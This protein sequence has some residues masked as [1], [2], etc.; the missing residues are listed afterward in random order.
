MYK[1]YQKPGIIGYLIEKFV[2]EDQALDKPRKYSFISRFMDKLHISRKNNAD[3]MTDEMVRY[4]KK[5]HDTFFVASLKK[6]VFNKENKQK[7]FKTYVKE[8][9][10]SKSELHNISRKLEA[11]DDILLDVNNLKL[12]YPYISQ[13]LDKEIKKFEEEKKSI[14]VGDIDKQIFQQH[15]ILSYVNCIIP[16]LREHKQEGNLDTLKE[17]FYVVNEDLNKVNKYIVTANGISEIVEL[18]ANNPTIDKTP[19]NISNFLNSITKDAYEYLNKKENREN[20]N[21]MWKQ[22]VDLFSGVGIENRC[23]LYPNIV[24]SQN[25]YKD[26]LQLCE[27][28]ENCLPFAFGLIEY[29]RQNKSEQEDLQEDLLDEFIIRNK[30][31]YLLWTMLHGN[32]S[33]YIK[34][35]ADIHMKKADSSYLEAYALIVDELIKRQ[36]E[37]NIKYTDIKFIGEGLTSCTNQIGDYVIKVGNC[38]ITPNIRNHRR[39]L[40]PI[41]RTYV[42]RFF[43]EVADA[44]KPHGTTKMAEKI[45]YELLEDG[46]AWIDPSSNNI[47]QLKRKNIPR[48][49]IEKKIKTEDGEKYIEDEEPSDEKATRISGKIDGEPLEAG[50][51]VILDT[52]HIF[53]LKNPQSL[54]QIYE[55]P[56]Q[57]YVTEEM[58][59]KLYEKIDEIE[60][61]SREETKEQSKEERD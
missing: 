53:D 9:K 42:G 41:I 13:S 37:K 60:K 27:K 31:K 34:Y 44:I 4:M 12:I 24:W 15:I 46:L 47:G 61:E 51:Y 54:A 16:I 29:K 8:L 20:N 30:N 56:I 26:F 59:K 35:D 58:K 2:K 6:E 11:F 52:D 55:Q 38:R 36:P 32:M 21:G 45:F 7:I 50:E 3:I 49:Y 39:L 33:E 43:I 1:Y 18:F 48:H 14:V 22:K 57:E 23:Y 17:M 10:L 5:Y 28:N 40:Q 19:E 25:E